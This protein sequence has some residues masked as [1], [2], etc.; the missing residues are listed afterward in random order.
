[1]PSFLSNRV[2]HPVNR[3]S[4]DNTYSTAHGSQNQMNDNTGGVNGY[5]SHVSR[6]FGGDKTMPIAIVG[7]GCRCPGDATNPENLWDMI[8]QGREAWNLM[9]KEKYNA[10]AFYHP[11]SSRNGTSNIL[12]GHFLKEDRALFDA[13]F[14]NMTSTEA[15]ALDPQQRLLLETCYEAIE[16]AGCPME[17]LVGSDTSVFVGSFCR[18]F[19]DIMYR[20]TETLPIFQA[21]G[22]GPSLAFLSNRLS[23]F[24]DLKG[25]S[26]SVD[27]ACSA[28]LVA[29]HLACQTIRSGESKQAIVGG[30]NVILSHEIMI[31]M[32][33]MR[34]LSPDGR[35]Y[36]FDHRANGYARGEGA[37]CV[38]LKS[39][40]AAL[41]DGDTIR[42]VIR[43]TG[44]NQDGKT[45]GITLPSKDAQEA[46]IASVYRGAGLDPLETSYIEAHG[47]GTPAGDPIECGAIAKIFAP[48]RPAEKPLRIGSIKSNMGHLEGA[49]GLA[50]LIKT[51]LMLENDLILPNR[52]F[53]K[54]NER[55]PMHDWRLR[56]PTT[57]EPWNSFLRRASVNSF[58]YGGTNAHV[59]IDDARS[60]LTSRGLEGSYR[61]TSS[62]SSLP[63][64][65]KQSA[66][67]I[68]MPNES[69]PNSANGSASVEDCSSSRVYVLSSFDENSGKQQAKNLAAYL[70]K[71]QGRSKYDDLDN[72]AFTLNERRSMLP[73]KTALSATSL[74]HLIEKLEG[75]L[76]LFKA[77]KVPT[78]GYVFTGQGAQWSAMG[79]ELIQAYPIFKEVIITAGKYLK[80]IGATWDLM[81]ELLKDSETSRVGMA[82]LS[83]PLCTAIQIALVDLLISWNIRPA[84][85]TGH[86][87]GEI[88]AAY[89]IGALTLESAMSISY[90]RGIV[91]TQIQKRS[92]SRGA[93]MAVGTSKN[94]AEVLIAGLT[95]GIAKVACENS[96]SSV[97]ISG[98][99]AAVS[100]LQMVLE[101]KKIFARKLAV[102]TA[103]H[104]HHMELVADDY[105]ALLAGLQLQSP[106][107][108][109]FYS[110]VTGD[111]LDS[112][113]LD[114]E[115]WVSNMVGQVRFSDSLRN[116]CL[117]SSVGKKRRKRAAGAAVDVLVEIG[118]HS[119]LAGPIKQILGAEAKLR[120]A[121][122]SYVSALK[123]NT[124]AVTTS[125]ELVCHLIQKGLIVN[126]ATVNR[127][128][129]NESKI[130]LVDLPPYAWNHS[131][132]LW[133]ESRISRTYRNRKHPRN[134]LLG[135]LDR[136]SNPLE[137]RWRNIIRPAEI[138]WVRDHKVQAS[139]VY[140][141]A[142]FVT[143]AIEAAH[144]RA[145]DRG[146]QISGFT[147]REVTIGQALLIP[148]YQ[149]E[150][151]TMVTLRPF[152]ESVRAPSDLWDEFCI[153]SV[154]EDDN[155]MEHCRGLISIQKIANPSEVNGTRYCKEEAEIY[156][157]T[158]VHAEAK[159]KTEIDT[160]ELYESL[161]AIGLDYGPT[162]ANMGTAY[163]SPNSCVAKITV[164]DTA[165][166]M[167][168]N[169]QFPYIL[170]PATLDSCFHPLFV[171]IA[172]GQGPITAPM[173]P[174]YI[175]ELFVSMKISNEPGKEFVVYAKSEKK[176]F[177]QHSTTMSVMNTHQGDCEPM[178]TITGLVCTALTKDV[179]G[180]D[181]QEGRKL[182]FA[183]HWEQ[184]AD[185]LSSKDIGAIC[186]G[187]LAP[188][189]DAGMIRA[190]EQAGFYYMERAL[191]LVPSTEIAK[192]HN[193]H[194]KLYTC[195]E[196]FCNAVK[197]GSLGYSTSE[198]LN[199]SDAGKVE[200][201][202]RVRLSSD[203]GNLLCH[204]GQNLPAILRKEIEPLSLMVEENRLDNYYA[205]NSRMS[206]NYQYAAAY[207]NM[208]AHKNPHLN[209]LEIG[210]GTG[211]ATMP[212]LKALGGANGELPRFT[213][214]EF[215]DIS[216]GFFE[217]ARSKTAAWGNL[218]TFRKLDVEVDPVDQGFKSESYDVVIAANVLHATS[219][220]NKIMAHVRKLLKPG[221]RLILVELTRE[222]MV[223]STIFGTLPGWWAGEEETRQKGPTLTEQEWD[224]LLK[225]TGYSG[226]DA[227]VWDNINE[228]EHQGSMIISRATVTTP[229]KYPE[230]T[231]IVDGNSSPVNL[232]YLQELLKESDVTTTITTLAKAKPSGRVCIVLNELTQSV[233]SDPSSGQFDNIKNVLLKGEGILWV[234]KGATIAS[235]T[236]LSNLI[237]GLARTA[238]SENGGTPIITLDLDSQ[239]T[240]PSKSAAEMVFQLFKANF[241]LEGKG[242]NLSETEYAERDGHLMVPRILEDRA[243]NAFVSSTI[244]V[245]VPTN[246][247]F[248]QHGRA[249]AMEIGT[250]G[251]LD[252]IHFIDDARM[253]L[254]LEN[255]SVEVK[256]KAAGLNF[257]D[258]MMAMGQIKVEP[259][260][261]ECSGI[262]TAIG[263]SVTGHNVGDRVVTYGYGTFSSYVRQKAEAVQR[264]PDNM[265]FE[266]GTTL[267]I[268]YCTAY[269][270]IFKVARVQ[271]GE[272]VLVHAASGGLGQAMI[273][274]CQMIGA[275]I[276]ATVGTMEKKEF[277]MKTYKIPEDHIFS[278]R[279]SSFA[280]GILRTT[281][282]KGID[283]IMN[284]V[285]GDQLRLTWDC[286]APF[287]RFIELGKRDFVV[288]TRLEMARF[289]RNVTFACVD[290][291]GLCDE[292]PL[293]TLKMWAEVIELIRSGAVRPPQPITLYKMSEAEKALR[294]MQTGKHLGKLVLIA[295]PEDM[296]QAIPQDISYKLLQADAS[297][298]LV[299]GLGGIGRAVAGW[300]M[301]HGAK[302]LIFASRSGLVKQAA[303]DV[304]AQLEAEGA[305][306][307]VFSCDISK[308]EELDHLIAESS[309]T[310]PAI[311]GVIQGAMVLRDS[312]F[313]NMTLENYM[314]AIRPKVQGTW[315]L[316]NKLS[317]T[318]LDFFIMLSST[319]GILGNA[320]QA[321]YAAASTFLDAFADYRNGLGM[322]AVTLDLGVILDVGYVAENEKVMESLKKLQFEGIREA[323]LMAMLKSAIITPLRAGRSG[324]TVTGLG[325][326]RA[327]GFQPVFASP[328]FSH[329]RRMALKNERT[330][331]GEGNLAGKGRDALR[332]ATSVEE[333]AK[334]VCACI[335][336]KMSSLLMIPLDDI[337]AAR[338]MSGH[339]I[340]SLVAVEMRNWLFREMDSTISILELL[341]NDSLLQLSTKIVRKSK[342][343]DAA[344][345]ES[346]KGG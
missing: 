283:V 69:N 120:D 82:L 147:L 314:E 299:G 225:E 88:A 289:A 85:V 74:S 5:P 324:Q 330:E 126:T 176:D 309:K 115:Y 4:R 2:P 136:N 204:I 268:I 106:E 278:S 223:L 286:I 127:P 267:P 266:V 53:E 244:R 16:N 66:H 290:F 295:D 243:L 274:L 139:M 336:A 164:P 276:F 121:A 182:C 105:R 227:A 340:D 337:N 90:Y 72:L 333:A 235:D 272:T 213:N 201:L 134:D 346:A 47:T 100:E 216:S 17:N 10:D 189:D 217:T 255:D 249:L 152:N 246:Q 192:M 135:V 27:T 280:K 39:L 51:V 89:A 329:F 236:P 48:G 240:L 304:V 238:R 281:K 15:A 234:I 195:M 79:R 117:G 232:D 98:D 296:I 81:D 178:I 241:G 210:A 41:K 156:K 339:G 326:W 95:Q 311:R 183:M 331:S 38:V 160:K 3:T 128:F 215:T 23:Y 219:S 184:D 91:T 114:A 298:L 103:Y 129:G 130:A 269:H 185:F 108:V 116:L 332:Q 40:E 181:L 310:M 315:N 107:Q 313:S 30:S 177:R 335:I 207:I 285:A 163:A 31:T 112:S 113:S 146:A 8:L 230:V 132:P 252:T 300:M 25:P 111:R 284:S 307:A 202:D 18:D 203:E 101:G 154:T 33:M 124:S 321:A 65:L 325:T 19:T 239:N 258:V 78:L 248:G 148:D 67:Q 14:F 162:F 186:S 46:L 231:I 141:A 11:D 275:E 303:K 153:F 344:I 233:L 260:G 226:V 263:K 45:A 292:R 221:A 151:E 64:Q 191:K 57:T 142:G 143:M 161:R 110:S 327:D 271:K 36:S 247:P 228:A 254:P 73:W 166:V 6:H 259:L 1:M 171:A 179:R 291:I 26:V 28:S 24:F 145:I 50:G 305:R 55:I 224:V 155:W 261:G 144:Q 273:M 122:I 173:V 328:M 168:M 343:V 297:Y 293:E 71:R 93:M 20:D 212:I 70:Q 42:G 279:D 196:V 119:A 75:D 131:T 80:K 43:N 59:I 199:E 316:H 34:F 257:R 174:T 169:F 118:P 287:G 265:S 56:V 61:T 277:L 193:H 200:V 60:Y 94:E 322:P 190:L 256:I 150:M 345:L 158:M 288:N 270:S 175:E 32:N 220:M 229:R 68:H 97:T 294:T 138:P 312:L 133:A 165:S 242:G 237:T 338:P 9:P 84:V 87:S 206:R 63:L 37:A 167:P 172:E 341:A 262:V 76:R 319:S 7:I 264:L 301:R 86:S 77:A 149:P 342:L 123:R 334:T 282:D 194:K 323:E 13:P 157:E 209:I 170:H 125:Q 302:N 306:V 137:P 12:G 214:Y 58:G 222:R 104:S 83:Q 29:L 49:S 35:C 21:T 159:C 109:E 140:P 218:I 250:P 308:G 211:G 52:N 208:L 22:G 187:I 318:D 62:L 253:L 96:P 54:A 180:E 44:L 198:W 197:E 317:K 102:D 99:E 92:A 251:L 188:L 320:S 245:A 205:N